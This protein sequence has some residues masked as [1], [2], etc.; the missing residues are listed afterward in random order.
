MPQMDLW[1]ECLIPERAVAYI[2]YGDSS[3]LSA[4][5]ISAITQWLENVPAHHV[6][7][8]VGEP[9]ESGFPQLSRGCWWCSRDLL[10]QRVQTVKIWAPAE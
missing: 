2:A 10:F 3:N 6:I 9:L 1:D 5:E 7:E 4:S 8:F